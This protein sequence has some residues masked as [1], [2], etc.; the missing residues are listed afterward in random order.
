MDTVIG[1]DTLRY[2]TIYSS[3]VALNY[4]ENLEKIYQETKMEGL[5]NFS[6]YQSSEEAK[7]YLNVN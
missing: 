5:K 2:N 1:N 6:T 7:V 3:E 4:S